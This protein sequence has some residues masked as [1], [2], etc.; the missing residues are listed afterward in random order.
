[1]REDRPAEAAADETRPGRTGCDR[2]LDERVELGRRDLVV[3]AQ[4]RVAREEELARAREVAALERVDERKDAGVLVLHVPHARRHAG[5]ELGTSSR[6]TGLLVCV[7]DARVGD[8]D[9][10]LRRQA[11]EP[12]LEAAAVEEH[13]VTV[14]AEDA[15]RLVEDPHRCPYRTHLGPPARLGELERRQGPLGGG[16]QRDRDGDLERGRR[17]EAR[18]G[19]NGRLDPPAEPRGRAAERGEL[20][21]HGLGVSSPGLARRPEAVGHELERVRACRDVDANAELDRERQD[22]AA[23]VVRVLADQV[24]AARS[25]GGDAHRSSRTYGVP[26]AAGAPS[27]RRAPALD[28]STSTT[29]VITYGSDWNSSG[30]TLFRIPRAWNVN[31]I[32]ENAPNRYAP[33]RHNAGRQ[34]AKITSAIA[35]QPAPDVI[36]STHCGVIHSVNV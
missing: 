17:R 9:R 29:T 20:G 35:I 33:T 23:A 12:M 22:E 19:R 25:P 16:T 2:P 32:P 8:D 15:R 3:V 21:R 6:V 1:E 26:S 5:F 24:D 30:G 11:H 27:R 4:A 7:G 28:T 13:R 18:S 31:G 34:N 10:P 36:P 14:A